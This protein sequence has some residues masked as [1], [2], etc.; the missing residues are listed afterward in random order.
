MMRNEEI[1]QA[2]S[3]YVKSDV[4]KAGNEYLA[5]GDFING[6]KWADENPANPWHDAK[7]EKPKMNHRDE[8]STKYSD[9]VLCRIRNTHNSD[10]IQY[11]D[12][13]YCKSNTEPEHFARI[14]PY[15]EVTHWMEIPK[16][17]KNKK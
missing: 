8:F 14:E 10:I 7:K 3:N 1:Q 11:R 5:Y 15:E 12:S 17:P 9:I 4:V 6:V 13:C 16:P 2:A